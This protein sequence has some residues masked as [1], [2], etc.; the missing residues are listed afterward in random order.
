LW[1]GDLTLPPTYTDEFQK[2]KHKKKTGINDSWILTLSRKGKYVNYDDVLR[3]KIVSHL[4]S[5]YQS[6]SIAS[7]ISHVIF[8]LSLIEIARI[9]KRDWGELQRQ[10]DKDYLLFLL[11][12][13]P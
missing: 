9:N 7:L 3:R 6:V 12:Q 4:T 2:L 8:H 11:R 1:S 13:I 5:N 10:T